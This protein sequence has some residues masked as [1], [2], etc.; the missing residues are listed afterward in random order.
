MALYIMSRWDTLRLKCDKMKAFA[1]L[2]E[3]RDVVYVQHGVEMCMH[4]K[5][6]FYL[7]QTEVMK[8]LHADR[9]PFAQKNFQGCMR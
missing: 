7:N 5:I 6:E 1:D 4:E 3:G 8:V 2:R 9:N